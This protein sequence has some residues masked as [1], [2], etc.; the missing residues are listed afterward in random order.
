MARSL[1]AFVL[2]L[3]TLALTLGATPEPIARPKPAPEPDAFAV[4]VFT[5]TAGYRHGSI[6]T[7]RDSI[8]KLGAQHGF[9]VTPTEEPRVFTDERLA[10]YKVVVFLNTT[11]DVL[12][13]EQQAAMERFVRNGGGFVGVHAAADTEYGWPWYAGLVGAQFK[14]HPAVQEA[15]I[16]VVDRDHPATRHLPET[17]TRTDEWYDFR[18]LPEDGVRILM[19]LDPASYQGS[20]TEGLHPIAWCHEY[21][22][23]RAFYTACGHTT[24]SYADPAFREHLLGA[25]RWAAGVGGA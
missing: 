1:P 6:E 16:E 12:N 9:S 22:G 17:W 24:E 19:A 3:I 11:G 4:L 14:S 18:A 8:A 10:H 5:R 20:A 25:I 15:R 7:G 2:A 21:D 13:D 23:G